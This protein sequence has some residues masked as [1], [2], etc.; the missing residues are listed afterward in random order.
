MT[1]HLRGAVHLLTAGIVFVMQ[2][3]AANQPIP[4]E[5]TTTFFAVVI[6]VLGFA[7]ASLFYMANLLRRSW[8]A[9]FRSLEHTGL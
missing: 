9:N 4:S 6:L 5:K 3:L 7:T 2:G 8:T 1:S